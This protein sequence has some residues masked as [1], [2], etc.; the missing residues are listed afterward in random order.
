MSDTTLPT[1]AELLAA[2]EHCLATSEGRYDGTSL[3]ACLMARYIQAT[4]RQDDDEPLG[5][6]FFGLWK[7]GAIPPIFRSTWIGNTLVASVQV[8]GLE[9]QTKCRTRRE[10]RA[11]CRVLGITLPET[12]AGASS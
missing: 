11:L 9:T 2:A 7:S 5:D 12:K 4:T 10:F 3:G 6:W 8:I 1:P